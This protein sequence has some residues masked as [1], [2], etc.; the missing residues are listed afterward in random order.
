M[1]TNWVLSRRKYS[2]VGEAAEIVDVFVGG[3][4]APAAAGRRRGKK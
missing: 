4:G 1:A 3:V 2:L